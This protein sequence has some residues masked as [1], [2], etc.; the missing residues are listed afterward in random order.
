[1][2]QHPFIFSDREKNRF[3]I[4][5]WRITQAN[6]ICLRN[7]TAYIFF[8]QII[9]RDSCDFHGADFAGE[10][11]THLEEVKEH[12]RNVFDYYDL[13]RMT[14]RIPRMAKKAREF[15]EQ[16][17]FGHEGTMINAYPVNRERH[18]L[19]IYGRLREG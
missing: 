2:N 7:E 10:P 3:D 19:L 4:F 15:L 1:M 5:Y 8:E 11:L 17:E 12:I 16:A 9:P 18:D 13:A 14:A 6:G